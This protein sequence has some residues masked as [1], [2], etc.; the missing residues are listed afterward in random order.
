MTP[1]LYSFRRCPYAM[2]AR[3]A[4]AQAGVQVELREVVLRDKPQ[5]F[6]DVS[7]SAS[8]PC[9]LAD[10]VFD[11]SLDIM[12]WALK[13]NDPNGWLDMPDEGYDWIARNDGSFKQALDRT[14]YET[15]YPGTDPHQQRK[16]ASVFL[17]DLDAQIEGWL[18]GKPTLAD[19]AI[20]PFVRQFA[21][22]DKNWFDAQ[23]WPDLQAWLAQFLASTK[24]TAMM[25]KYPQWHEGDAPMYFP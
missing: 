2:R 9:L 20:L 3:I 22:I 23:A 18:F 5:A 17:T 25:D 21:F 16:L 24:F 19:Y 1:I 15:R 11:E 14:K 13:Q 4:L 12:L 10:E 8:V 6:L 7:P